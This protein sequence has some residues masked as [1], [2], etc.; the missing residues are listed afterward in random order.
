MII[1]IN[2]CFDIY[3]N[4]WFISLHNQNVKFHQINVMNIPLEIANQAKIKS[5]CTLEELVNMKIP[6][7]RFDPLYHHQRFPQFSLRSKP[8]NSLICESPVSIISEREHLKSS[9]QTPSNQKTQKRFYRFVKSDQ[10]PKN[11]MFHNYDLADI[12]Y[13]EFINDSA[14]LEKLLSTRY[15]SYRASRLPSSSKAKE[16]IERISSMH[17]YVNNENKEKPPSRRAKTPSLKRRKDHENSINPN[18]DLKQYLK[19]HESL[20]IPNI[21]VESTAQ[22]LSARVC[23]TEGNTT[24]ENS[25]GNLQINKQNKRSKSV[26]SK[27]GKKKPPQ[28]SIGGLRTNQD[29]IMSSAD[30]NSLLQSPLAP[31]YQAANSI[32]S[33]NY[34]NLPYMLYE[35]LFR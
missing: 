3:V 15:S 9:K 25:N 12:Q 30:S 32:L 23:E 33:P 4:I 29:F 10:K 31:V 20:P 34:Q 24:L 17:F 6:K 22:K 5:G 1:E 7:V 27:I 26:Q 35:H 21:V 14:S 13:Q 18:C 8:S 28:L 2:K 16:V 11:S 19:K